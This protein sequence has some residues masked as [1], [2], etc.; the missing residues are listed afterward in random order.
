MPLFNWRGKS[1]KSV[2]IVEFSNVE[3]DSCS[4]ALKQQGFSVLSAR[5]GVE[6]VK[7]CAKNHPDVV[8]IDF[9]GDERD[10]LRIASEI[11][12]LPYKPK[13][14]AVVSKGTVLPE[15]E[16]I[17]VELFLERP[18]STQELVSAVSTLVGLKPSWRFIHV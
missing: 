6:A 8:L 9:Y 12:L 15:A 7:K 5:D 4:F 17:G 14:V 2:L 1:Q 3:L 10:G 16:S 11:T 13:I 18:Y